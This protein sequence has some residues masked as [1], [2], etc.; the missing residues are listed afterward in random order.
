MS[1]TFNPT[2][3][4]S[5]KSSNTSKYGSSLSL[6]LSALRN[7]RDSTSHSGTDTNDGK[8][9]M[10]TMFDV[11]GIR[12]SLQLDIDCLPDAIHH[13]VLLSWTESPFMNTP[14]RHVRL[15]VDVNQQGSKY[16]KTTVS[17]KHGSGEWKTE[18]IG[19]KTGAR[20]SVQ[21][22]AKPMTPTEE[23]EYA[24]EVMADNWVPLMTSMD[25]AW[26]KDSVLFEMQPMVNR[27]MVKTLTD[28]YAEAAVETQ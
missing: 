17:A 23:I 16:D 10:Y 20:F 19:G 25:R 22:R 27:W 28:I 13:E 2:G 26:E 5:T 11:K 3:A 15:C 1:S 7:F 9:V 14:D 24:H 8:V 6:D 18:L 12:V 4:S 21:G